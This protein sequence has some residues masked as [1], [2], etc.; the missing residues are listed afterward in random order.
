MLLPF[1]EVTEV[2]SGGITPGHRAS[3]W[4]GWYWGPGPFN[5]TDRALNHLYSQLA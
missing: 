2:E 5:N 3:Q 1:Y 4:G